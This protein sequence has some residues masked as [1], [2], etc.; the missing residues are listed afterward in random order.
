MF[1][2][3]VDKR[4]KD[5]QSHLNHYIYSIQSTCPAAGPLHLFVLTCG[6]NEIVQNEIHCAFL[7]LKIL[8]ELH[9]IEA[10]L[11]RLGIW[12]SHISQ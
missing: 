9:L 7:H 11:H 10:S 12:A 4:K 3:T 5:G 8:M 1:K 2:L 6:M